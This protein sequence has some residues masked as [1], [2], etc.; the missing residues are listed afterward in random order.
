MWNFPNG[1]YSQ[2]DKHR[3]EWRTKEQN[4]QLVDLGLKQGRNEDG[5]HQFV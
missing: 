1:L 3:E 2:Q 5:E 4:E